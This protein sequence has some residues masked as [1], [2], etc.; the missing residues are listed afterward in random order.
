MEVL[1]DMRAF[2]RKWRPE[3][4]FKVNFKLH[5]TRFD[6]EWKVVGKCDRTKVYEL[7]VVKCR[8]LASLLHSDSF[9]G[10]SIFTDKVAP[11][12]QVMGRH[13]SLEGL[14]TC[15]RVEGE[16]ERGLLAPAISQI[17]SAYSICQGAICCG[18]M[19][20]IQFLLWGTDKSKRTGT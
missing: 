3:G 10:P 9:W 5:H 7:K 20:W 14:M 6:E 16:G 11:F 2:I 15:L 1:Y 12:F 8:N 17:P 19:F 4:I 18:S 13:L